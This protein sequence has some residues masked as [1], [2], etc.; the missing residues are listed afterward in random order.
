M[1]EQYV[2]IVMVAGPGPESEFVEVE[3]NEGH[4]LSLGK[5]IAPGT[6]GAPDDSYW[7]LR[8]GWT[9]IGEYYNKK[10]EAEDNG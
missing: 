5:W 2:D 6:E 3:D 1:E 7:R 8:I 4:S 9:D 10:Y